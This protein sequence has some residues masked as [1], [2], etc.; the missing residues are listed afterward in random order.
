MDY[1]NSILICA[2]GKTLKPLELILNR[3][4]R[5]I[6]ILRLD[7]HIT[8]YLKKL[9]ILPIKHRIMY[10]ISLTCFKIFYRISPMHLLDTFQKYERRHG[11]SLRMGS[12]RDDFMFKDELPE[13]KKE[14]IQYKMKRQWN[15]LPMK[16]RK[17]NNL[18]Q[19]KIQLKTHLFRQAFPD[20]T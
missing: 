5:F 17:I 20:N 13:H 12:G 14:S 10:K 6:F 16:I 15:S 4:I 9:H 19:F 8:P 3:A 11:I 2:N 7:T 1:C 18:E